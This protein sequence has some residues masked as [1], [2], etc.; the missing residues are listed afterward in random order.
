MKKYKTLIIF[1]LLFIFTFFVNFYAVSNNDLIWNYGFCYNVA[2]GLKMYKDF[3]MV[4]TPLFPTIFGL[5]MKLFG[6]NTIIFFLFNT[7]VPLTIYY[8]VY[9][10]YKKVFI[11]TIIL[12]TFISIPNY[13]LLCMMFLFLL[14][15]LEDKN[16]N[17]YLIGIILG[18]IFLTKSP[19]GIL[20]LASLYYI[21]DIKKIIK[22]FIGFMIPNI[23]YIIYF[24]INNTLLDYINY[25][26]GSLF[27]FATKNV[28]SGVGILI[29]I[30]SIILIIYLYK[31][32]K[33]IKL[34][35]ILLF[36]IMSYPI[37][38][39]V[40]LLYSAIP[41]IFYIFLNIDNKIYIK[42][43]KY[44]VIV[45]ICP[46]MSTILQNV[47]INMEYGTNALKYKRVES[48]YLN[49]SKILKEHI[50]N[51]NNTYFIM[52]EAYYN[53][54]LLNLD[55]NKYDVMLSGNLGYNGEEETIKYFDKLSVGSKFILY[56][57][58]EGGQAPKKIYDHITKNY[59]FKDSFDKY[60]VY[61]K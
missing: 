55:I 3:N 52:Y 60:V 9:K 61:V 56:K 7:L 15:I 30:V 42:Y 27:D 23:I 16:K 51:F 43:K 54:L 20:T 39:G 36:Q 41:L 5:L 48:K 6:N 38:N 4:I 53:K 11:E 40:H 46:I 44:L 33:D 31:K 17:D 18:L 24:Y 25:A 2:K 28:R 8:T 26:F 22:R 10:Y 32:K 13:N 14:F 12:I 37:F 19:M 57:N 34:I 50:N 21:K 35:Y 29:F 1:T 49:D 47:F 45:L 59:R 58:Y